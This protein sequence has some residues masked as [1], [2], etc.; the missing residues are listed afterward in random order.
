MTTL[1]CVTPIVDYKAMSPEQIKELVRD[2]SAAA[3]CVVLNTPY[4][5]GVATYLAL[6]RSV[7]EKGAVLSVDEQCKISLQ[8]GQISA[9]AF[10]LVP[11]PR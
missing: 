5:R 2:K 1:G 7:L 6:D 4:G 11:V 9:P 3:N 10:Q 8:Q